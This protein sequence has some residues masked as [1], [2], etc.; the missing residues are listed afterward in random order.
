MLPARAVTPRTITSEICDA[1]NNE[2]FQGRGADLLRNSRVQKLLIFGVILLLSL[3]HWFIGGP[4]KRVNNVL[5]NLNFVPILVGA[6]LFGWRNAVLTTALTLV[7]E[8]PHLWSVF[9]S[10]ETYRTDQVVE[11]LASGVAGVVVGLLASAERSHRARL[12]ETTRELAQVNQELRDNLERLAKAERM[13]AVAQ[14]SASLA[15]EIRNPLASISGAAGILKRGNASTQNVQECLE[16]IDKES[17]RLNKLLENF[18]NFARPRA[19]RFQPTDLAAVID[20]TVALARHSGE[21]S[22]IEFRRTIDGKLPEVQCDSEQ[23]KQVLLN[24]LLNA[25][26]ATREGAVDLQAYARDGSAFITVRDEGA[27]IPKSQE[28]RIF[29]PFFTTKSNGT[30][31]GLAIASK[32]V[33]QHGGRLTAQNAPGKGLTMVVQLPINRDSE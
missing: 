14:L 11:T 17:T 19:P 32:I 8:V 13:Y 22:Q 3:S 16:V 12:E 5:Y 1:C 24:L 4:N 21:A 15:H 7:S 2:W 10:D 26:H 27:G 33:E 29:E 25:A 30:G 9:S 28:D 23:L 31:L 18:L 20:S 6:M